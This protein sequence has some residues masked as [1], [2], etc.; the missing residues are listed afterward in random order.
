MVD[1]HPVGSRESE[2]GV[3]EVEEGNKA[4]AELLDVARPVVAPPRGVTIVARVTIAPLPSHSWK[5]RIPA[6]GAASSASTSMGVMIHCNLSL[7]LT[8]GQLQ[9][10]S[11]GR[12]A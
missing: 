8:G 7:W 6:H 12:H 1:H 11:D 5:Q 4:V 9:T 3:G 2:G 10:R